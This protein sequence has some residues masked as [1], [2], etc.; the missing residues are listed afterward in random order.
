M[1]F[2]LLAAF[3]FILPASIS[4]G[5]TFEYK[6]LDYDYAFDEEANDPR[7][8][9]MM[10]PDGTGPNIFTLARTVLDPSLKKR[11]HIDPLL[12]GQVQTH[13]STSYI[14]D[15]A[16]SATAYATGYKT[17]D[18][19]I[20]VDHFKQPLGTILEAAKA[21]GMITGMI[22][23]SRVTHATP[24]SFASHV[25]ER[26]NEDEI[27][28]QYVK[29]KN[30]DF[31]LGGG[32][33]HFKDEMLT[34]MQ[35]AGYTLVKNWGDL[36]KYKAAN[37]QSGNLR[38]LGLFHKSH[39]SYEL[40]RAREEKSAQQGKVDREPS[41]PE[42]V[43]TILSIL[44]N[45]PVAK[46]NGFFM[47][48]EGS[49]VDHAGH[50][51]DP[52][53]MAREAITFDET[54]GVVK[55]YISNTHNVGLISAADHGTGGLTLGADGIYDWNPKDLL[56]QKA[57]TEWMMAELS[58]TLKSDKCGKGANETCKAEI[59]T[60]SKNLLK[61]HTNVTTFTPETTVKLEKEIAKAV[62]K[63]RDLTDVMTTVKLEKEIAKAV[64][65]SRDLTD[66]MV[67]LGHIISEPALIGWTTVGHVGTDV[68]LHCMGPSVLERLC[69]GLHENTY[70]NKIMTNYLNLGHRQSVETLRLRNQTTLEYKPEAAHH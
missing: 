43:D 12:M 48:I 16:S 47:M 30:L 7:S 24:A 69:K 29:N 11:L 50:S 22:V 55:D 53:T 27:A 39:M 42:M 31:L 33:R 18:K 38:V 67:E 3:A 4:A 21:R 59:L 37:E 17:Y 8:L 62:D 66:V 25:I 70:L 58:K 51:N 49:R 44:K 60:Q 14:T 68:D 52:G 56:L 13:S 1:K 5:R 19:G 34:E 57:S 65:K 61:S 9:I 20:G 46:K 28:R 36:Q 10:I 45:N 15:S 54:V 23:T 26:D 2:S 63:S 35:S 40:D 41:L 64:D 32:A 6:T